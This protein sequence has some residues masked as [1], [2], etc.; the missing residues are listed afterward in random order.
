M[1]GADAALVCLTVSLPGAARAQQP[2]APAPPPPRPVVPVPGPPVDSAARASVDSIRG[3]SD[4]LRT[5]PVRRDSIQ[6]PIARAELPTGVTAGPAYR[7]R[8]DSVLASGALTLLDLLERV[9]GLASF[10]SGYLA[11][12]QTAAYNGDFRRVRV[13]RDGVELDPVDP[14]N[15]GVL[16]LVDVPIWQAEEIAI[17]PAAGEVRVFI[18]TRTV[19]NR[20]P[21]TR[22]DVATGDDET[23]LYRAYYGKRFGNGGLIQVNAQQLGTG[24]RNRRTGGGGDA[25]NAF[26][27]LGWARRTVSVDALLT[28]LQR[29]RNRT[30]DFLAPQTTVLPP[31]SGRRDE[32]YLRVG[33]GDPER[34]VWAQAIGNVLQFRNESPL[35]ASTAPDSIRADT[36]LYRAQ[37]VLT[38]GVSYVGVR[39]TGTGRARVF[40]GRTDFAPA[41]RA[42]LDR[43]RL[44]VSALAER[45]GVDSSRR[46]DVSAR[47]TPLRRVA[48]VGAVSRTRSGAAVGGGTR[49]VARAEAAAQVGGAWLSAGRVIRDGGVFAPPLAYELIDATPSLKPAAVTEP[50]AM[51]TIAALRGRVYRDVQADVNA[52]VWDAPGNFRPRYQGRAELRLLTNWRSR[53]PS[54]EFGANLAVFDEYRSAMSAQFAST[55]ASGTAGTTTLRAGESNQLGALVEVRLQSAVISF[56]IRNALGRRL[57]YVPG[58]TAPRAVSIYGVRWEFGN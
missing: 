43:A 44:S 32:G 17:E 7:W 14:R 16:D 10:R 5:P 50:R 2:P 6:P 29:R 56:Q 19:R 12:V 42:S 21:Q 20:T 3:L 27:R 34:G 18:R 41:V 54:G 38:G 47:L 57:E 53:F 55:A 35:R 46:L 25:V 26:V 52:V 33:V 13:F 51:G 11:S 4:T 28:R 23:N 48:F 37:Y 22:V 9:P 45:A 49:N 36:S 39:L 31:F 40:N 8:G 1:L 24:S 58:L 30:L 15:G